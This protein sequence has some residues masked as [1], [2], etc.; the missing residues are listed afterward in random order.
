MEFNKERGKSL[1]WS[2]TRMLRM[3]LNIS[4][5]QHITNEVLY[6]DLPKISEVIRERRLG[7]AGHSYRD[8]KSPVSKLI[9]WEPVHGRAGRGKPTKRYTQ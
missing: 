2:Y 9:L 1:K 6:G 8:D 4:W 3:A 5:R 7:L